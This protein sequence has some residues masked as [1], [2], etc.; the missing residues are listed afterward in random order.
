MVSQIS[1]KASV[2]EKFFLQMPK[3][4]S[5]KGLS[6]DQIS[7]RLRG[8]GING[9]ITGQCLIQGK[10]EVPDREGEEFMGLLRAIRFGK[11][12]SS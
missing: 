7:D 5:S 3:P 2:W 1:K 11:S 6:K 12:L 9:Q 10:P 4:L 8:S